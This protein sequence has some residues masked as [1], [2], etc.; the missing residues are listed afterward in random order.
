MAFCLC[1]SIIY[2]TYISFLQTSIRGLTIAKHVYEIKSKWIIPRGPDVP[3]E[4]SILTPMSTIFSSNRRV[5]DIEI[6]I[7]TP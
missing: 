6:A 4:L 2:Y 3:G 7:D 1:V 5:E